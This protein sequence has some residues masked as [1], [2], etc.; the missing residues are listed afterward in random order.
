M[1]PAVLT[2][3]YEDRDTQ[4]AAVDTIVDRAESED[5]DLSGSDQELIGRHHARIGELDPQIDQLEQIE[6][7]RQAHTERMPVPVRGLPSAAPDVPAPGS[8]ATFAQ[9]ARDVLITRFDAIAQRAGGSPVRQAAEERISRAVANTLS[10]DV[11][12]LVP[13]QYLTQI[14]QV[15]LRVRPIVETARRVGLT[16]GQL[17]YPSI[18]Q[19]PIVGK[20]TAQKTE[21]PS[22]AMTVAFVTVTA[23]TYVGAGDIS[24]QA[25][26]WSTPDCLQLWFDLA[27]EQYGIQT[28]AA[29][30]TVLAAAT[31]M[32][33]PAIGATPTLADW[34]A[35]IV[36]A[37]GTVYGAGNRMA[38]TIYA[39]PV[40][41]YQIL[42][43]VSA[44]S[45]VFVPTGTF[46][47]TSGQGNIAGLRLVISKGLPAK[48]VV[49]GDSTALL[50]AE[51]AGAPVELRAVEPALGGMEVG[52][53]GAFVSK[54]V[55]GTGFRKLTIA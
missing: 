1:P 10:T 45:P 32:A 8:Y 9:Y 36:A 16:S 46:S 34:M 14:A 28:E 52:V 49:V 27:A 47:L 17:M 51:T 50:A 35:A 7:A 37:A 44:S 22:Q 39:D 21:A 4:L 19:R 38:D 42:G 18:T 2:R 24:W 23:D 53:I 54:I 48:T 43:Q 6:R 40:T 33:T 5:R 12:G 30:G 41:G 13:P 55:D 15:I 3:L 31:L 26:N 25:I 29:T 11:A 20:Q